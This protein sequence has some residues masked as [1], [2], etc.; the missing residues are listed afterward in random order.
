MLYALTSSANSNGSAF[1]G[2]SG[3]TTFYNVTLAVVM[4]IGRYLPIIFVLGL[5]GALARQKPV[6]ATGGMLRTHSPTFIALT[7]GVALVLI[8]LTFLPALSLG[9]LAESLH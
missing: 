4:L 9:P 1:A 2:L 5:A 7:L 3:D 6:A 8:F